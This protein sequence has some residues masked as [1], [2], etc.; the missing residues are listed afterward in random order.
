MRW[1]IE[2]GK[3]AGLVLM[4]AVASAG[5]LAVLSSTVDAR[6]RAE[7]QA[8]AALIAGAINPA[9]VTSLSGSAIDR[10]NPDYQRLHAQLREIRESDSSLRFV[11]LLRMRS[12]GQVYFAVDSEPA[13][14]AEASPPGQPYTEASAQLRAAV[15]SGSLLVDGP[16][17]DRWGDWV[18]AFAPVR[19]QGAVVAL[20]GIDVDA[21][22][23]RQR[24]TEA[25]LVPGLLIG[26]LWIVGTTLTLRLRGVTPLT[27]PVRR[28]LLLPIG[29]LLVLLIG[30]MVLLLARWQWERHHNELHRDSEAFISAMES[31]TRDQAAALGL[32]AR[33]LS[34]DP[35]LIAALRRGDAEALSGRLA[36]VE[37]LLR[38]QASE[39]QLEVPGLGCRSATG[40]CVRP[41][42]AAER[43]ASSTLRAE[44]VMD[45]YR[46]LEDG[47]LQ[48]QVDVPLQDGAHRLGVLRVAS[49][50]RQVLDRV[51]THLGQQVLLLVS[52]D[53]TAVRLH[54]A[55]GG[56]DPA[57]A[58]AVLRMR[59]QG[60]ELPER[61]TLLGREF[62]LDVREFHDHRKRQ[63]GQWVLIRPL[64]LRV[65]LL[66]VELLPVIVVAVLLLAVMLS[67]LYLLLERT[68]RGI[69]AQQQRLHEREERLQ[70]ILRS[71]ADAVIVVDAAGGIRRMNPEAVALTGC[72]EADAVGKPLAQVLHAQDPAANLRQSSL[73]KAGA[74]AESAVEVARL[75]SLEAVLSHAEAA[76]G[77]VLAVRMPGGDRRL[78]ADRCAPLRDEHGQMD[79]AVLVLRDVTEE[80]RQRLALAESEQR[81][82]LLIDHALSGFVVFRV[83]F[84]AQGRAQDYRVLSANPAFLEL[85]GLSL[86]AV[87]GQRL[88][89][90]LPMAARQSLRVRFD[91]ILREGG[92]VRFEQALEDAD[93]WFLIDAF[94]LDT[95][96]IAAVFV[97]ISRRR[98]DEQ[99]LAVAQQRFEEIARQ[100][101]TVLW[102][103][104]MEGLYTYV[105]AGAEAV[106]GE[107][108]EALVGK[109]RF[110]ELHPLAGR[111]Q[112]RQ[113][114]L[115]RMAAGVAIRDY[116]NLIETAGGE[117][118]WVSTNGLPVRDRDG[119]LIGYRGS[120]V[121]ITERRRLREE[122]A[123]GQRFLSDLI[124]H[125]NAVIYVRDLE[126]RYLLVNRAWECAMGIA[127]QDVLG[128]TN[129]DLAPA[130]IAERY[131]RNDR[132]VLDSERPGEFEETL[133]EDPARRT[134]LSTKF[135]TRDAEGRISGLCGMS[136]E[137][138]ERIRLQERLAE[139]ERFLADLIEHSSAVV[140]A[141]D[142]Q[143]RYLLVNRAWEQATGISR[144]QALGHT[145][146]ELM[147]T[148]MAERIWSHDQE[149]FRSGVALEFEEWVSGGEGVRSFL[150]T[151]FPTRD[152]A[153]NINGLCGM[154]TEITARKRA[155]A[156]LTRE[157]QLSKLLVGI[158][159]TWLHLP[160]ELLGPAMQASLAELATF[161]GAERAGVGDYHFAAGTLEY[162]CHWTAATVPG[163][164]GAAVPIALLGP[165]LT[166][167]R[168]GEPVH[169]PDLAQADAELAACMR[170]L[171]GPQACSLLLVPI[172]VEAEVEG[173]IGFARGGLPR[174]FAADEIRLLGV[175][176]QMLGNVRQ[177]FRIQEALDE[178][179]RLLADVI[180]G[181][182]VGIWEWDVPSGRTVFNERW[183]GMLG[184]R[185]ADLQP[186]SIATWEG[187]AHPEDLA[188]ARQQLQETFA[189]EVPVYDCEVRMRRRDGSW[190]WILDRGRVVSWHGPGEPQRVTGIHLDI[191]AQKAIEAT[192]RDTNVALERAHAEAQRLAAEAER[193]NLAKSEFLANMS[194]E[195]RTP[196][197]GVIGMTGL[198]LDTELSAEQRRYAEIVRGSGEALLALI[199]DIL[200]FSK[201]EAGRIQLEQ[202]DF[203]LGSLLDDFGMTMAVRAS[204]KG[205]EL[206]CGADA[207]VPLK[208]RGDPARL[209]QVL[210]NLT[211]NAIKFTTR[212]E[213]SIRVSREQTPPEVVDQARLRFVVHDTGIGIAADKQ[214]LIFEKFTQA[215]ASTTRQYGGTGLGLA[216]SRQLARLMGGDIELRSEP[217]EGAEF[218]FVAVFDVQPLGQTPPA[219]AELAGVHVLVVDDNRSNREILMQRLLGWGM[220]CIDVESGPEALQLLDSL[221]VA[222]NP[223][224]LAIIDMQMPGMDGATLGRKIKADPA[225]RELRM[226][227]LTSLGSRGDAQR[228]ADIGFD[229]YLT[230]PARYEELRDVLSLALAHPPGSAGARA[231]LA[232]R[233]LAREV[234]PDFSSE[235]LRILLAEDNHTNQQV[236]LGILKKLGVRVDV[237]GNGREALKSLQALPYD[238]VFM[239]VQMPELDGYSATREIRGW[240]EPLGR[241]PV[242]AMTAHALAGDRA[243][244]LAAGMDDYIAK[245]ISPLTVAQ[246]LERWLAVIRR[247]AAAGVSATPAVADAQ[248]P[249]EDTARQAV[250]GVDAPARSA[251]TVVWDRAA[252]LV[253]AMEDP[254]LAASIVT[255]FR[256]ELPEQ[257]ASLDH[258]LC[259]ADRV[260]VERLVHSLKSAAANLGAGPLRNLAGAAETAAR[261]DRLEEVRAQFPVLREAADRLL[262]ALDA[263]PFDG[264]AV[265]T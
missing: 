171:V 135:P 258:A 230:K 227:M 257:L 101:R 185:L 199:N 253:R 74:S 86:E 128:K 233:H 27:R 94:G 106:L 232:T 41:L 66:G 49:D 21:A 260:L 249:A 205:L 32:A 207:D 200:D 99:A 142:L 38:N 252:L 121:D 223:V 34:A 148:E 73:P 263:E 24:R 224:Q 110:D 228:F 172:M 111:E 89:T 127:R 250:E 52:A 177:R 95:D 244:C 18:S 39:L 149:V 60:I 203:D 206:A 120:D 132:E 130:R 102:E 87:V 236:A 143:G 98:R 191:S 114:A 229:G 234:L 3:L 218:S 56:V 23:W 170:A 55:A 158:A 10:D 146:M 70:A 254:E 147:P 201:G 33:L 85:L 198:L 214:Q 265:S 179:H 51:T 67:Y 188:R 116:E 71:I 31:H 186:V 211:D 29:A 42:P 97:D 76:E 115:S 150:N 262:Q 152:A 80:Q 69:R 139:R 122:L 17:A 44:A 261:A 215:D 20:L 194:H 174:A 161:I 37:A 109:R 96:Q 245:P 226:V 168:L 255:A 220:R 25:V 259:A 196:M 83:S 108:P 78:L 242:I 65:T 47:R 64:E 68:D 182:N 151:K 176:A 160:A 104:D 112:F 181:A 169:V 79:G 183:A 212:G 221:R 30:A 137:I 192:L 61:F 222:G 88:D 154:G 131:L 75:R 14:S 113:E 248:A 256:T 140:F 13:S 138:T 133:G 45:G 35:E 124:D 235:G 157:S 173:F 100:S 238:L 136:T 225:L 46:L 216:I 107:P 162:A 141:K 1:T 237:V 9:R 219:H 165:V 184:Y 118:Y 167:H 166:A 48:V 145:P 62:L 12:D 217:G 2:R 241:I 197:N 190:A 50:L 81:L 117:R 153:G 40:V 105:S 240:A 163:S 93:R 63:I 19:R 129:F 91:R 239:D 59:L 202:L 90:L 43:E 155:E 103:T 210:S 7:L 204:H 28:R 5:L 57:L 264:A 82:R 22:N 125:S 4:L 193:A 156:A 92:A 164:V 119:R 123:E 213:V 36:G 209:R 175:F 54:H 180:E 208:L 126:G 6:L 16:A 231:T 72:T 77:G 11:Y 26:L 195:I 53:S 159:A 187:L 247:R 134:F 246:L 189:Q 15:E 144:A 243:H 8:R 84:D 58:E 178:H 251:D